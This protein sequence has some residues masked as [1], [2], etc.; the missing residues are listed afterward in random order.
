MSWLVIEVPEDRRFPGVRRGKWQR[1]R[2]LSLS[3]CL[4]YETSDR[5]LHTIRALSATSKPQLCL[6]PLKDQTSIADIYI[7]WLEFNV[8]VSPR[9]PKF[10]VPGVGEN[11]MFTALGLMVSMAIPFRE[12]S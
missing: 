2:H 6:A 4:R 11:V 9:S 7:D 3:R 10:H 12:Q 1:Y 8:T 5:S